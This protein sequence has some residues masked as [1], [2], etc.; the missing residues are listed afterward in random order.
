MG[1]VLTSFHVISGFQPYRSTDVMMNKDF[2]FGQAMAAAA[3]G[4]HPALYGTHLA[5]PFG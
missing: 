4:Y 5:S 3:Y 2:A 1:T